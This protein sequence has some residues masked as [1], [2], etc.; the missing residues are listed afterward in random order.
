MGQFYGSDDSTNG[1]TAL[2]TMVSEPGQ[3]PISPLIKREEIS[4]F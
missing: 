1:V 2:K 4:H 3:G